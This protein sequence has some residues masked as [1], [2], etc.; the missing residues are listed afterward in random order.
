[1]IQKGQD[2]QMEFLENWEEASYNVESILNIFACIL[3][4]PSSMQDLNM[5]VGLYTNKR[6]TDENQWQWLTIQN[7]LNHQLT[8]ELLKTKIKDE[9]LATYLLCSL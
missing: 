3:K 5:T 1:M 7:I 9:I 8:S 6:K 4:I 2:K